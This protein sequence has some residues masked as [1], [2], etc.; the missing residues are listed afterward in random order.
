M[1]SWPRQKTFARLKFVAEGSLQFPKEMV[2]R[3]SFFF[4]LWVVDCNPAFDYQDCEPYEERFEFLNWFAD[5][6]HGIDSYV[7]ALEVRS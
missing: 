7:K 1:F 3:S 5:Q 4:D 6:Y 2:R